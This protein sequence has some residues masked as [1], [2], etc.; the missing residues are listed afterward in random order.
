MSN[1]EIIKHLHEQYKNIRSD[2]L[3]SYIRELIKIEF[4]R[5]HNDMNYFNQTLESILYGDKIPLNELDNAIDQSIF[6]TLQPLRTDISCEN[7]ER[8]LLGWSGYILN[9]DVNSGRY[10][11]N[12]IHYFEDDEEF[13]F[14]DMDADE[15]KA[16]IEYDNMVLCDKKE[17]CTKILCKKINEIIQR[18]AV[19]SKEEF[20][21]N[22]AIINYRFLR[23]HPF[24]DGNG[25]I[26]RMLYNYMSTLVSS[27]YIP[28]AL[29]RT[30][31]SELSEIYKKTSKMIYTAFL[32]DYLSYLDIEDSLSCLEVEEMLT[33]EISNYFKVKQSDAQK[34]LGS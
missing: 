31:I 32:G 21:N 17:Q 33:G 34:K 18:G 27:R 2:L 10:P 19:I 6:I 23:I 4:M 13:D 22:L 5:Y 24:E 30:E 9:K 12:I 20:D 11:T 26:S 25:R 15:I 16:R 29:N 14:M 3:D 8:I 7:I 28:I 1:I